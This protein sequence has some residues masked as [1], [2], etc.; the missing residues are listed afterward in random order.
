MMNA[1]MIKEIV[2]LDKITYKKLGLEKTPTCKHPHVCMASRWMC[3]KLLADVMAWDD[4]S[5][6]NKTH[7]SRAAVFVCPLVLKAL[8]KL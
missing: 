4:C 6:G 1:I 7:C 3:E 8:T 5:N 2:I